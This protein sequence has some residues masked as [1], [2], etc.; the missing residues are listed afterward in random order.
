MLVDTIKKLVA[1]IEEEDISTPSSI[2][3]HY[4]RNSQ[5]QDHRCH[6]GCL[7]LNEVSSKNQPQ[8]GPPLLQKRL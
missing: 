3:S 7:Q 6:Q 1:A 2:L 5:P 8:H 4:L